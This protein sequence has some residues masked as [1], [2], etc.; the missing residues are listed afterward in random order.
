MVRGL[1]LFC[2]LA[3]VSACG[4]S[5][6]SEGLVESGEVKF[7]PDG[8]RYLVH[9]DRLVSGGVGK[10]GIPS[11]DDPEFVSVQEG[12]GWLDDDELGA[13]IVHEGVKR[14]YPFQVLV[15]HEIVN[16]VVAGDAVLLTYCPLC[17]SVIG[18]ERVVDGMVVEFGVSGML[19]NSNLVMYDRMTGTYWTQIG[20]RGILGEL[21]GSE[22]KLFPVDVVKWGDWKSSHPDSEVLSRVTGYVRSY[23]LDPYEDYYGSGELVFPVDE[24]DERLHPKA[25]VFGVV[26]D[27][28]GKAY[29]ERLLIEQ[30]SFEDD[31][32]GVPVRVSRDDLGVVVFVDLRSG[33]RVPH[34]RDFWFAW[35]AFHPDTELYGY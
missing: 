26:I 13:A 27:G 18:F 22:L 8:T 10:D 23:G 12:D 24:V 21:S 16:D 14:F 32:S 20:G 25:V 30:G 17:G 29:P 3:G 33:F 15:W 6:I 28:V 19:L 7:L 11:I 4:G 34:E 35:F 31:V 1:I 5:G 9:P 2:L